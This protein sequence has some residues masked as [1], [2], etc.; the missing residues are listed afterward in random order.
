[1]RFADGEIITTPKII[2]WIGL[3]PHLTQEDIL[4]VLK[5]DLLI[6][7]C[8]AHLTSFH[9]L[10]K[11]AHKRT[12]FFF[13]IDY[14]IKENSIKRKHIKPFAGHLSE[15]LAA[16]APAKSFIYGMKNRDL[17]Q[18]IFN[19]KNISLHTD[20]FS[21]KHVLVD[22]IHNTS[23]TLFMKHP[24]KEITIREAYRLFLLPLKYKIKIRIGEQEQL[25][26]SYINDLSLNGINFILTNPDTTGKIQLNTELTLHL[27][28][29]KTIIRINS[30]FVSRINPDRV[31]IG[32]R[33]DINDRKTISE[34]HGNI[35]STLMYEWFKQAVRQLSG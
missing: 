5:N 18:S 26:N 11:T 17:L 34:D 23:D 1:M 14:I 29:Y 9:N 22:S 20:S 28:L 32:V 33:Y 27:Y 15:F 16:L 30:S 10:K 19:L 21:E 3:P 13:N 31:E 24:E 2:Y 7:P 8:D 35:L 12:V 25:L 4:D 6:I